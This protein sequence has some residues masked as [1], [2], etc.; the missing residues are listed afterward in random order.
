MEPWG[1]VDDDGGVGLS[2]KAPSVGR[3]PRA[4]ARVLGRARGRRRKAMTG[5][6]TV[7]ARGGE[8]ARAE[9]ASWA[10]PRL[11]RTRVRARA[12][13]AGPIRWAGPR[14]K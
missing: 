14:E 5:G 1:S 4:S 3:P 7:S 10:G 13:V 9:Q 8:R 6:D 2:T 12:R 11:G